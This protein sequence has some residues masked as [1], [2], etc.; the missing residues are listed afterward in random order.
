LIEPGTTSS[1]LLEEAPF[2]RAEDGTMS[3]DDSAMIK[4]NKNRAKPSW[5]IIVAGAGDVA[6]HLR[7]A[8]HRVLSLERLQ[9][10]DLRD[11]DAAILE[12]GHSTDGCSARAFRS[13]LLEPV[14]IHRRRTERSLFF[15]NLMRRSSGELDLDLLDEV[16]AH[17][18][19]RTRLLRRLEADSFDLDPPTEKITLDLPP[20]ALPKMEMTMVVRPRPPRGA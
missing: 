19:E 18:V 17:A 16:V 10:A 9:A 3:A 8:G 2:A 4:P 15:L 11:A 7:K 13:K 14:L 1:P 5:R 20:P 6:E 12:T